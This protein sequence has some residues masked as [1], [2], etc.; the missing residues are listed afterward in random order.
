MGCARAVAAGF[1]RFARGVVPILAVALAA[2]A[3]AAAEAEHVI[4]LHGL[5][6]S[7]ASMQT[8]AAALTENGYIVVNV[9]YASRTANVA[10]LAEEAVG[11]GL[12]ECRAG[13]AKRVHFVTHSL[14]GILVR[15][16]LAR[17]P[18]PELG[19]VVMLGP[20]NQGSE[21]VDRIG[22]WWLFGKV[23]GPAGGEL[24]TDAESI[25]NKLG[26]VRYPVG[27]IAGNR[28][29]NW[30][31]SLMIPG[32]DDGKVSVERTKLAGMTDHVVVSAT[33]PLIMRDKEALRQTIA[34]LRAGRFEAR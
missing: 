18:L 22:D 15:S 2:S 13:K 11:R 8:M 9:D 16:Y 17:H 10:A 31:N 21:V 5:A 33:H 3:T 27:V 19:R 30:V 1:V 6:R 20:P 28:S 12:A 23:N 34:F 29:I 14:G 26:A 32:P 4:L 25:P 7:S 24:G